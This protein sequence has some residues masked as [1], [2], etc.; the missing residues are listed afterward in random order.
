MGQQSDFAALTTGYE[1]LNTLPHWPDQF[2]QMSELEKPD[3][4]RRTQVI[5]Q[6]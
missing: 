6:L 3:V 2:F 4:R 1:R 5:L